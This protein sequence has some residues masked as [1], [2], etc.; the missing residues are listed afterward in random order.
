VELKVTHGVALWPWE[1]LGSDEGFWW[2]SVGAGWVPPLLR[3]PSFGDRCHCYSS[4]D[5]QTY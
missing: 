4:E 5:D 2:A 3:M 1:G